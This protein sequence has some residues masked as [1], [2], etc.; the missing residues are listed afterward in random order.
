MYD[1]LKCHYPLPL[2]RANERTYQTKDLDCLMDHYEIREDGTLWH[3]IYD[4]RFE[5]TDG[6]PFGFY[7]HRDNKR[8]EPVLFSG[9]LDFYTFSDNDVGWLEWS[10]YF[11]DGTLQQVNLVRHELST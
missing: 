6:S 9:A 7:L 5:K 2:E 11:K 4:T 1:E 3:E 8:W 10:A